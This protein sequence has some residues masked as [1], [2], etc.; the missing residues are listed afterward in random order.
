MTSKSPRKAPKV[1]KPPKKPQKAKT[2]SERV[3]ELLGPSPTRVGWIDRS[4]PSRHLEARQ[5]MLYNVH[6]GKCLVDYASKEA[7]KTWHN[8][9]VLP[10]GDQGPAPFRNLAEMREF[11]RRYKVR[12]E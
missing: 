9:V 12:S 6:H 4:N 8:Y 1:S 7:Q 2:Q 10:N 11:E 3:R 5:K